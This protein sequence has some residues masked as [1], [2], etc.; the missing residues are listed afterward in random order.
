[1]RRFPLRLLVVASVA[2]L[3]Q[4]ALARAGQVF[5]EVGNPVN[6]F[7]PN[8]VSVLDKGDIVVW[9][10][11]ASGHSVVS[12]STG[13]G[14]PDGNFSSNVSGGTQAAN[15]LFSWKYGPNANY[16]YFCV[17]HRVV[18]MTGTITF[19]GSG[20]QVADLRLTEVRYDGVGLNFVEIAN[21]GDVNA[22]LNGFRLVIN[23]IN[24]ITLGPL[25]M[26]PLAR[27]AISD[28]A[29]LATSGSVALYA[30]N[31]IPSNAI[32]TA[33]L[34]DTL[35]I[36][37]VAWGTS[38]GQPLEDVAAITANPTL[39]MAGHFAPQVAPG[40]VLEFCGARHQYGDGFWTEGLN[41]TPGAV[42]DCVN[43]TTPT[44]WGRIKVL[45]R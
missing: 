30:P 21:L 34:T 19:Q 13:T 24:V 29:G 1:M 37:Y 39:W 27:H 12:G 9:H 31:T 26:G 42:N 33:A 44:T 45:Y 4:A 6:R 41:P 43:P 35:M 23:G 11:A 25:V 14:I 38:G 18:G 36:D 3:V 5:I 15:A 40:H 8:S 20:A 22:D 32:P 7:T 28:P 2:V 10:W 17:P 16:S